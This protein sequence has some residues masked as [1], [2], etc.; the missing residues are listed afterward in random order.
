M[1]VNMFPVAV[2]D[3]QSLNPQELVEEILQISRPKAQ[4]A[5]L[6]NLIPFL[7]KSDWDQLAAALKEK[8]NHLMRA[9]IQA[10]LQTAELIEAISDLTR[11]LSYRAL[12]GLA[13][14]NAYVIG[15]GEF[16]KG[17]QYCDKAAAIYEEQ[18]R[19]VE[20]ARTQ[21][22]K[23][24][25]L[26]SLGRYDE[27]LATGNWVSEI[28][29]SHGEWLALAR[30]ISNLAAIQGRMGQDEAA[31]QL[32]NQAYELYR[33][34]GTDLDD[35][36][37]RVKLNRAIVLRNLGRFQ[38][39][40]E[41]N[42][43]TLAL[44]QR[45]GQAAGVARAKQNLAITYYVLGR[46]NEALNSLDEARFTFLSD[47]RQRHAMSVELFIC[48]CLLQ[49]GRF[50]DVLE[51]CLA[52]RKLFHDLGTGFEVG[53][54]FFIESQAFI[55]L[56][57]Y[58]NALF[59]LDQARRLFWE[60]EN[61]VAVADT[62]LQTAYVLL[63]QKE[64]EK[65]LAVAEACTAVFHKHKLPI[66]QARA[67]LVAARAALACQRSRLAAMFVNEALDIGQRH[68]IPALTYQAHHLEGTLRVLRGN[69]EAA[70]EAYTLA[71]QELEQLNGRLMLEHRSDFLDGKE[72]IYED[73][74]SLCL[75]MAK[76]EQGL[77]FAE[78]AKSR[79]LQD[80]LAH[81]LNLRLET[82]HESD[83]PLV[84]QL[85]QLR[86]QRDQLYRRWES[87]ERVSQADKIDE[88]LDEQQQVSQRVLALEKQI[89]ALWHKL[90][91]RNADYA[92]DAALWQVHTEPV[93]HYLDEDT[94]LLEFFIAD[95]QLIVF[96]ITAKE[97]TAQRLPA[98]LAQTQNLLQLFR[99]NL[100]AVSRS[101]PNR[102]MALAHN[103]QK[104]LSQLY[105]HLLEPLAEQMASFAKLVIVPHGP[106]HY[107]PF[108]ALHDGNQYLIQK[109]EISYLPGS[110]LWRYCQE[111]QPGGEGLLAIGNNHQNRF[112]HTT[113]EAQS[114]AD[115]WPGAALLDKEARLPHFLQAAPQSRIIH[116]ATH[117]EFRPDN[118]LFSG[119][120]LA[121]GWLTTLDIFN[122][123]L[124]A[125]LVTLSACQT[126][127]SVI[128][129]GDEL[130]GLMRAFLSAGASSLVATLWAVEDSSTAQ[131]M[132]DFYQ[133]LK[134]GYTKG[135]ALRQAQL[136]L[137]EE[138]NTAVP[139][140]HPF[141][142]AP[143][144]LVGSPGPL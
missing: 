12:S 138:G 44:Y 85:V 93:Q 4:R 65:S 2:L 112:A 91:I 19:P 139:H 140:A 28:F 43:R 37:L 127:R 8:A 137:I 97:I 11:D 39:S 9:D 71:I 96:A 109:H 79:A 61:L 54:T 83:K 119:L 99:L 23:I 16:Q 82:R 13:L 18:G 38:E 115:L 34:H 104:L 129:G 58:E 22:S 128:G 49:L 121:D 36:L 74:V 141:F 75:D 113:Q 131:L 143:F 68:N 7:D 90:L 88:R 42:Q 55:G 102:L 50:N 26:A 117:G 77:E 123:R 20:Q 10:C 98:T 125:S 124:N 64:C 57:R 110:S 31:L 69:Q 89:T 80:L 86:A 95:G 46:Y 81:R 62:D 92:R 103:A 5:Y 120:A 25:A 6:Q 135:S 1:I 136:R 76:P 27:A 70:L 84:E 105:H 66:G 41:L 67:C 24:W 100:N 73:A 107:L 56:A 48:D 78:R 35:Q 72:H 60:E 144:Y 130:L 114:I 63:A 33:S 51:K 53:Q 101:T 118:P 116:L 3:Q 133:Q 32:L 122:L 132:Q 17:I 142:W 15:L 21:I 40:I 134:G 94:L 14:G 30:L 59:A 106:L 52:A 47:D 45:L 126:G 29:Q 108:H 87:G 111:M